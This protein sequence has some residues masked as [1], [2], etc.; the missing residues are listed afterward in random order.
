MLKK[1]MVNRAVFNVLSPWCRKNGFL[2]IEHDYDFFYQSIISREY[3]VEFLL[4][5][6]KNWKN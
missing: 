3:E 5:N 1:F 6:I 2:K 4:N